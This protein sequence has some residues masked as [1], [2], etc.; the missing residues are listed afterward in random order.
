MC[1]SIKFEHERFKLSRSI[2]QYLR[3]SRMVLSQS[4]QCSQVHSLDPPSFVQACLNWPHRI[5]ISHI[6]YVMERAP[7]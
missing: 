2:A 7:E 4:L 5:L 6:P 1:Q 3:S